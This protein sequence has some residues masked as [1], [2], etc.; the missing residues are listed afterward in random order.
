MDEEYRTVKVVVDDMSVKLETKATMIPKCI[1]EQIGGP[2]E[3][4]YQDSGELYMK[5]P[6]HFVFESEIDVSHLPKE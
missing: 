3:I 5:G 1:V 6:S 2:L 4:E